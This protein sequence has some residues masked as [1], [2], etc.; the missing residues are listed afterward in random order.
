MHFETG[1]NE[2]PERV[3]AIISAAA[4][5]VEGILPDPPAKGYFKGMGEQS[6]KFYVNYWGA[7]NFLDL[8]SD[9]EQS[10]YAALEKEGIKMPIPVQIEIKKKNKNL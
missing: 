5:T 4:Q 2:D 3:I 6:I 7:G 1:R 10:V 8:M 9:V